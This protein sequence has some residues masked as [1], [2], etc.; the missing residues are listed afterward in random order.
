MKERKKGFVE[1]ASENEWRVA[2]GHF[3]WAAGFKLICYRIHWV[4]C[5]K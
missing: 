2:I 4:C 1:V 3:G 5:P